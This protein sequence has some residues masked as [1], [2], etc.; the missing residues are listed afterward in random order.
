MFISLTNAVEEFKDDPIIINSD[1]IVTIYTSSNAGKKVNGIIEKITF[2]FCP[3]HGT[4]QVQESLEEVL[5]K[6]NHTK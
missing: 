2:V 4:W 1:Y 5:T 6:L 3:P